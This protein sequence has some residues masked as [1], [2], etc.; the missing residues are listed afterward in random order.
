MTGAIRPYDATYPL[1]LVSDPASPSG[2]IAPAVWRMFDAAVEQAIA[3]FSDGSTASPGRVA[4]AMAG[5]SEAVRDAASGAEPELGD[6]DPAVPLVRMCELVRRRMID[7]ARRPG[8]LD[9]EHVLRLLTALGDVQT[10]LDR[11]SD[12]HVGDRLAGL[13]ARELVVE[14]AH[15]MR[16]PLSAI[17]FLVDTFRSGRSGPLSA[18][19]ERQL[20][21]VYGAAFGLSQ[22]ASD[23]ID[24]ARGGERLIDR[25]PIPFSMSELL[26]S[27]RDIIRPIAEEKGLA[28]VS[29]G[30]IEDG[31]LGY[32]AALNRVLLNLTTN[33]LKFTG[34]GM[35]EISAREMTSTRVE[36]AV[37]DTGS[38]IPQEVL[39]A[40]FQPFRKRRD[41]ESLAFTR[42]GLGLSICRRLVRLMGSELQVSTGPNEGTRFY[43]EIDLPRADRR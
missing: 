17:L 20:G 29:S 25:Q 43:F 28:I 13:D 7:A 6:A 32:P 11:A 21:L 10:L 36:I 27:V 12:T 31:R 2:A 1:R 40:L 22:L 8:T 26:Q 39:S 41:S 37:R 4:S 3:A 5:V 15:D 35:V 9:A 42:S 33:A 24:L 18:L 30:L 38:G 23:L 19:Q 14:V 16:S 34:A